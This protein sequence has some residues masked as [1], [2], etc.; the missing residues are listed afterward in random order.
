VEQKAVDGHDTAATPW[1]EGTVIGADHD[2]PSQRAD[3]S[4]A[5]TATQKLAVGHDREPGAL[6][7]AT[8]VGTA[9]TGAPQ[10]PAVR[11]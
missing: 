2:V 10:P 1:A 9:A 11:A 3:W 6:A 5:A 4:G 8:P 7:P